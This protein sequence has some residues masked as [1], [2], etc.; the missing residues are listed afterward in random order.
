VRFIGNQR[1]EVVVARAEGTCARPKAI[2]PVV[3]RELFRADLAAFEVRN[4]NAFRP[5]C[6]QSCKIGLAK[7]Q[8]Q[9][10]KSAPS[11]AR[12]SKA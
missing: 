1:K 4:E 3:D 10:R 7:V 2:C 9:F 5:P 8:G 11:K 6:Q 12:I